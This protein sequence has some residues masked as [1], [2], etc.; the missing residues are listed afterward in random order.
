MPLAPRRAP[1]HGAPPSLRIAIG[2]SLGLTALTAASPAAADEAAETRTWH[3]ET[4]VTAHRFMGDEPRADPD[5]AALR[6]GLHG[7]RWKAMAGDDVVLGALVSDAVR[8]GVALHGFIELVNFD[9][10]YPVPWESYRANIGLEVLAESPRLSRAILPEG[11]R[12]QLTLGWFHESDHAANVTRYVAQYVAPKGFFAAALTSFDNGEFSSYEYVKLRAVYRQPLWGGRLT[13]MSAFGARLFPKTIAPNSIRAMEAAFL[14]ETRITAHVT[15]G[16]RPF[17]SAYFE[18]LKNGFSAS[19]RGF[20]FGAE[21][22]PLRYA[23]LNLGVDLVSKNGAIVSPFFSYSRSHGRGVDFP[24][25]F[26]PEA[27]FGLAILP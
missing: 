14:A 17:V 2:I 7:L 1:A 5:Q 12:L 10:G 25:Y 26:G 15:G 24:R 19:E 18:L 8:V 4:L 16:V 13:A 6:Y 9:R 21:R 11:G 3:F 23:I 22:E 20:S 27:G